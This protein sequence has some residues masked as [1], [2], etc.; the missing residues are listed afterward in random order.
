[1]SPEAR[2][3]KAKINYWN[4][5]K[6]KS[7]YAAKEIISNTKRRPTELQKIFANDVSD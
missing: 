5:I 2:E 6:T 7:F 4:L 3:I 1:M